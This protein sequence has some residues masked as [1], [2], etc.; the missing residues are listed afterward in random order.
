[1]PDNIENLHLIAAYTIWRE[2]LM[3]GKF[4]ESLKE[5]LLAK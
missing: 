3:K 5:L 1:M 4:G 2:T